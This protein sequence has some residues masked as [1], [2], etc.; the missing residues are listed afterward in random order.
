MSHP[1]RLSGLVLLAWLSGLS[2]AAAEEPSFEVWPETD[3]WLRFSPSWK[4]SSFIALS[5]NIE[6]RYREG[7]LILQGDVVWGKTTLLHHARMLDENR[8]QEVKAWLA[9]CGVLRGKSLDDRGEA[10]SERTA[11]VELH[12]RTPFKG[13]ELL[14]QRIRA[15][16]RWL[17]EH[18]EFSVRLRYRVML[19]KEVVAAGVSIVP[20][21]NVE[22]YYDSRYSTVN[23]V[24]AI[25][26]ATV[27]WIPR[28]ALEANVT[29]QYDSRSSVAHLVA[30]NAILHVFFEV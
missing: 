17:G 2:G 12:S 16:L 4:L 6:T 8:A 28:M 30:L 19:E 26:G 21:I 24:R 10:Y 13:R 3:L 27:S 7:S 23:R 14:S 9:R 20:Y 15:D 5:K 18:P 11:L 22:P 25:G 1:L 29:Y